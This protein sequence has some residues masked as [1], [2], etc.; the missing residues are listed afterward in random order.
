[1]MAIELRLF[2]ESLDGIDSYIKSDHIL[3]LF[4]T[5]NGKMPDDKEK[6]I[7]IIDRFFELEPETRI[8]YQIGRRMGF[9]RGPEDM[10]GSP[11]LERVK[12]ACDHY[13]VTPE[14]VDSVIDELMKRF[15]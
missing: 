4:E 1:M 11:H 10:D 3:N 5:I 6:M 7:E 15:V 13:G 8:L 12:K 9:F 2:I 14:N